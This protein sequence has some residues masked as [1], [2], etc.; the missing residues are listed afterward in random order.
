VNA[1][2]RFLDCDE[3]Y[4][5]RNEAQ[6]KIQSSNATEQPFTNLEEVR[7]HLEQRNLLQEMAS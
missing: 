4:S 3:K 1:V 6:S 7:A 5:P 2:L